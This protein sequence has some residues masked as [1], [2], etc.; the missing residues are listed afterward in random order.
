MRENAAFR[1]KMAEMG[2][3][4]IGPT[5]IW[6][7]TQSEIRIYAEGMK[8]KAERQEEASENAG[9][10]PGGHGP[11]YDRESHKQRSN[12]AFERIDQQVRDKRD[13]DGFE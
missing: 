13:N 8:V 9:G 5:S 10:G 2:H 7:L 12:E 11:S 1:T 3:P 4:V 6:K